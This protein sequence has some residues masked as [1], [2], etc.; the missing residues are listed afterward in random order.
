M[1]RLSTAE[2]EEAEKIRAIIERHPHNRPEAARALGMSR[3]SLWRKMRK[4]GL[5]KP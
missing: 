5:N 2:H 1:P 4:Y 3:T